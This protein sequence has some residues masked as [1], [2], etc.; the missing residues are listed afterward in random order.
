[1]IENNKV[2]YTESE[3]IEKLVSLFRALQKNFSDYFVEKTEQ[4]GFSGS[5]LFS[6]LAI[7]KNPE[8]NIQELSKLLNLSKST[9]SGI[10]DRLV[11]QG[12]IIREIPEENRRTVKLSLSQDFSK[13]FNVVEIRNEF[14]ADIAKNASIDDLKEVVRGLEKFQELI[15]KSKK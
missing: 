13:K 8:I 5:Q 3:Y 1:M 7:Y 10:V 9:V 14:F 12:V 2:E 6:I 15:D 4:F 11:D